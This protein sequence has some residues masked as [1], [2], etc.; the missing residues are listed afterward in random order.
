MILKASAQEYIFRPLSVRT[1]HGLGS[2]TVFHQYVDIESTLAD[3]IQKF[4]QSQLYASNITTLE[5][6]NCFLFSLDF[7]PD[8]MPGLKW[9]SFRGNSLT[10]IAKLENFVGLEELCLD[11]NEIKSL[12]CLVRLPFLSRLDASNNKIQDVAY[13]SNFPA[14]AYLSLEGNMI[15]KLHS[16]RNNQTLMELCTYHHLKM[17]I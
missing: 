5:L 10:D 17:Q 11:G 4:P 15:S 6:D 2:T 7:M 9:A 14:L 13:V 8:E 1:Y 12:D 3:G 16:F